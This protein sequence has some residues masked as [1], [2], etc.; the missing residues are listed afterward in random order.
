MLTQQQKE[1]LEI[2][3]SRAASAERKRIQLDRMH[4]KY[5]PKGFARIHKRSH[6][7]SVV[8]A[9]IFSQQFGT[10]NSTSLQ[11]IKPESLPSTQKIATKEQ[12]VFVQNVID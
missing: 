8:E 4:R 7:P 11:A 5:D 1:K 9:E 2:G 6:K 3:E 12:R 10:P